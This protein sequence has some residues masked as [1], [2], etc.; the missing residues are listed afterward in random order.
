M[1]ENTACYKK[2]PF[3]FLAMKK[4]VTIFTVRQFSRLQ[5]HFGLCVLY[6]TTDAPKKSLRLCVLYSTTD[7]PKKSLR[8]RKGGAA[9]MQVHGLPAMIAWPKMRALT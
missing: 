6:S 7:A 8:L 4:R 2:L 3:W 5:T 1:S 9:L